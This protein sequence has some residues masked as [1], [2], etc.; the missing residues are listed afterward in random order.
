M[1]T[2]AGR[3]I[4][5]CKGA[6]AVAELL[7]LDVSSVHKWKYPT[8]RGGTGGLV[9]ANRQQ[10]LLEKARRAGIELDPEDFFELHTEA[11]A[12]QDAAA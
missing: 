5:K 1:S 10:E 12:T 9:P 3:I 4:E 11:G 6:K 8:E 2:I 7:N